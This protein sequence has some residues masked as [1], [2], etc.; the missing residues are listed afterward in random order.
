[1]GRF[2][3]HHITDEELSLYIDGELSEQTRRRVEAHLRVCASCQQAY[4]D[5]RQTVMLLRQMPRVVP[6]RAFTLSEQ[7]VAQQE[8]RRGRPLWLRWATAMAAAALV[9]VIALDVFLTTSP[10]EFGF[11]LDHSVEETIVSPQASSSQPPLGTTPVA[12]PTPMRALAPRVAAVPA[13]QNQSPPTPEHIM[14]SVRPTATTSPSITV[15]TRKRYHELDILKWLEIGLGG[16]LGILL[17]TY[18]LWK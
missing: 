17:L 15:Q 16:A 5:M 2:S 14:K 18:F 11:T 7:D 13:P 8:R 6:P 10:H 1:M 12:T 4:E 3:T 9:F